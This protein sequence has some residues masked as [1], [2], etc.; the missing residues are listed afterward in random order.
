ME[1]L[2]GDKTGKVERPL[3]STGFLRKGETPV[4]QAQI[5]AEFVGSRLCGM[6]GRKG[7]RA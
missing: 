6:W 4:F 1:L 3:N 7:K 5:R 2:S